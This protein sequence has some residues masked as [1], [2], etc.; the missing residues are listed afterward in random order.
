MATVLHLWKTTYTRR[1]LQRQSQRTMKGYVPCLFFWTDIY[2]YEPDCFLFI[3]MSASVH[4]YVCECRNAKEK[5]YVSLCVHV[6]GM[7]NALL[8]DSGQGHASHADMGIAIV[9]AMGLLSD[10]VL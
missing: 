9:K 8:P 4:V 3:R 5:M 1:L 6:L 2:T 10:K 7:R